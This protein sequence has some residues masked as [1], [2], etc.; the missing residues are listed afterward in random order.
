MGEYVTVDEQHIWL[1]RAALVAL[2]SAAFVLGVLVGS[3]WNERKHR[4]RYWE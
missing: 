4:R 2:V 1:V 3:W